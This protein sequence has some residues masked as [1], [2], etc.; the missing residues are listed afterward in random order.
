M[1]IHIAVHNAK[2]AT[3]EC[4]HYMDSLQL[5]LGDVVSPLWVGQI[6]VAANPLGV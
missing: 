3:L 5:T 6:A 1:T 4:G 2:T